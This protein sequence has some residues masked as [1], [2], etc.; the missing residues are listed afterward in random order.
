MIR[1]YIDDVFNNILRINR[2]ENRD[3]I[4]HSDVFFKEY[5]AATGIEPDLLVQIIA[6]LRESHKILS[7]EILKEDKQR[8]VKKIEAYLDA[9]LTT[10]RR[11]KHFFQD[12]LVEFYQEEYGKP[13]MVHQIIQELFPKIHIISNTPM[14]FIANKAIMLDEYEKL[15]EKNYNEYTEDFK[16]KKLLEI[17]EEKGEFLDERVAAGMGKSLKPVAGEVVQKPEER[18][19]RRAVDTNEFQEYDEKRSQ[20]PVE[21]L[22][23][24]YGVDFFYRVHLRKYDFDYLKQ[25]IESGVINRKADLT[26]LKQMIQTVKENMERDTGLAEH[27]TELYRLDRTV[28]QAIHFARV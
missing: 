5:T 26:K 11:L 4:P 9:D 3:A 24:I 22:L 8:N 17:L 12:L 18:G 13:L 23:R 21:T 15:L 19:K 25:V 10:I 28:S 1:S 16:E 2:K 14:G 20:V 6:I 7:F 27:M